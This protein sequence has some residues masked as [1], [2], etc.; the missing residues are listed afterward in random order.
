MRDAES[1]PRDPCS[2]KPGD[3]VVGDNLRHSIHVRRREVIFGHAPSFHGALEEHTSLYVLSDCCCYWPVKI[4]W[5]DHLLY[6][7]SQKEML[8]L[9]KMLS[10]AELSI[11]RTLFF[12]VFSSARPQQSFDPPFHVRFLKPQGYRGNNL[13][14]REFHKRMFMWAFCHHFHSIIGM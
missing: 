14:G 11:F 6:F 13:L 3:F 12:F 7:P 4:S 1:Y 8:D 2:N 9:N 10:S 5:I